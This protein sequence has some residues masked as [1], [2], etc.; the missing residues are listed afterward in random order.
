[1]RSWGGALVATA[2]AVALAGCS[3]DSDPTDAPSVDAIQTSIPTYDATAEASQAVLS[4]V[5]TA[6]VDLTV[7]DF[8][9]VRLQLGVPDLT[10]ADPQRFRDAFWKDAQTQAPLLLGGMLREVDEELESAFGWS[11]DDVAWEAH[12]GGPEGTGW[13]LKIREDLPMGDIIRAVDAGVGPLAGAEVR[14]EDHLVVSNVA[15]DAGESWA[16]D[17]ELLALVGT[18]GSS[19]YVTRDCIPFN[20]IFGVGVREELAPTPAA[21]VARVDELGPFSVTFGG[22]L[23]TVRLGPARS[24]VFDRM[25]LPETLPETDPEFGLGYQRPAADPQGGR[26]GW[27]LGDPVVAAQLALE[28]KLP[29][30]ICAD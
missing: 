15:A 28:K 3:D 5:P 17:P 6:A 13:V 21:D 27:N 7:T 4:L 16:A 19:T 2:L 12:F 9:Q 30:A 24:D 11:Q 23:A 22:E 18:P 10:G 1:M 20:D 8:D 25:R 14:G 26:I 29:F